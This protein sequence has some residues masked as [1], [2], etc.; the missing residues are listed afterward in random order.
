MD[1]PIDSSWTIRKLFKLRSLAQPLIKHKIGNGNDTYVWLDNWHPLGP[2]YQKFGESVVYNL[3]RSLFARVADIIQDGIWLWPR[4]R[5][6]VTLQIIDATPAGFLPTLQSD[7]EVFCSP[8]SS[9]LY[10]TTSAWN[11]IRTIGQTQSWCSVVWFHRSVPKWA[12]I[13]WLACRQR[14]ATKDRLHNWGMDVHPS[15]VLCHQWME[16][17]AHLFF[18]C[19]FSK[20]IW[21]DLLRRNLIFRSPMDWNAEIAWFTALHR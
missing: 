14:L 10:S 3:G 17:H 19:C 18:D 21:S 16:S 20:Y 11:A 4:P 5:N 8:S 6:K 12:F 1:L 15:C 13:V 7:D 2:L 9:G